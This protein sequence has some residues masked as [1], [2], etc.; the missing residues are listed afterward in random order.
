MPDNARQPA[1]RP[2]PFWGTRGPDGFYGSG[3]DDPDLTL[4][5]TPALPPPTDEEPEDATRAGG[6]D[7]GSDPAV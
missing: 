1:K 5:A 4:R 6:S 2:R 7:Q 3:W